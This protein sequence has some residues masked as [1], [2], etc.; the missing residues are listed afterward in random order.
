MVKW[1]TLSVLT[2]SLFVLLGGMPNNNRDK[3]GRF[4]KN[5]SPWHKGKKTG[6]IPRSAFKKNH[7]PWNKNL[8]GIKTNDK[9]HAPFKGKYHS[10]EAKKKIEKHHKGKIITQEQRML[11]S[12]SLK[13]NIPW[14]KG[15]ESPK[16][17]GNKHPNWQGGKT[18]L[19]FKIRNSL[20]YKSWRKSIFERDN[21]TCQT[22]KAKSG[23]LEAHHKIKFSDIYLTNP[24]LLWDIGNGITLCKQCHRGAK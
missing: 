6:L 3:K 16:I 11:I 7:K 1:Q 4:V 17:K 13:G 20:Q 2:V 24:E 5:S 23:K 14:N 8:T 18:Q 12:N 15:K 22:C 10:K 21:Y 19:N 9:G